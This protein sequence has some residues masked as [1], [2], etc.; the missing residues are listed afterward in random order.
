[1]RTSTSYPH[2]V[3]YPRES[4]R[5][6][7]LRSFWPGPTFEPGMKPPP[8]LFVPSAWMPSGLTMKTKAR[9]RSWNVSRWI[10]T[11]SSLPMRSRSASVA[12]TVPGSAYAR[13][14]KWMASGEYQTRTSVESGADRP[15]AG[16]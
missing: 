8:S 16:A 13:M 7:A 11:L 12:A 14:P 5:K 9:L 3:T 10:S 2:V 1:M 4:Q 15:S 6:S